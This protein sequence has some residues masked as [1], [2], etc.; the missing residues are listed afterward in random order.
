MIASVT[1]IVVTYE[2]E[3]Q[4][5]GRLLDRL[6]GDRIAVMVVDNGSRFDVAGLVAGR[7]QAGEQVLPLGANLGIA[8][9]QNRGIEAARATGSEAVILFDQDSLPPPGMVE[10][11]A[12]ALEALRSAG[13]RPA[14]VGPVPVDAR[15]APHRAP[16][17]AGPHAVDHLIASGCLIPLA[18]LDEVGLMR[19]DLFIDYVDIEWCLRAATRGH[20]CYQVPA[21]RMAHEFGSP[22][23]VLGR[24]YTS[25]SPMRHYYLFRNTVWLWRQASIPLG[26]RFRAAPRVVARLAFNAV[27]ARP[28]REQWA[29][30]LRG[31]GDGLAGRLGR[32]HD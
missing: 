28:H 9:A 30:M 31:L 10:V 12:T 5:L 20:R 11:L 29:M 1:A 16:G 13:L 26:W 3:P 7:R 8:A 2:P 19:E 15:L 4:A 18:V 22:V 27:F 32:R 17:A 23:T 24:A 25:H 21:A 14:A 6:A